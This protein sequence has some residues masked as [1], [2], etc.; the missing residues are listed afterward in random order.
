MRLRG[1]GNGCTNQTIRPGGFMHRSVEFLCA[2]LISGMSVGAVAALAPGDPPEAKTLLQHLVA[3]IADVRLQ[4]INTGARIRGGAV[5]MG[6]GPDDAPLTPARRCCGKNIE[7][8]QAQFKE[9]SSIWG[10]LRDCYRDKGDAEA[11]IQANFVRE[12][13][14][15]L[16]RALG[17]F[18][19]AQ[20]DGGL[21]GG[22]EAMTRAYRQLGES[23]AKLTE[24]GQPQFRDAP[25]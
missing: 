7:T 2:A 22:H 25:Q 23:S 10:E 9:M 17:V 4:L 3:E 21:V 1:A 18:S 5:S 20:G 6:G 14:T 11:E 24:C 12:D 13:A 15:S 19:S 8:L 16:I